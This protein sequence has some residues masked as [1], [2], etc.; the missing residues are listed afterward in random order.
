MVVIGV[1][2]YYVAVR[3][4]GLYYFR[5]FSEWFIAVC[6]FPNGFICFWVVSCGFLEGF[7]LFQGE[8]GGNEHRKW[9]QM[10]CSTFS[11]SFIN[12]QICLYE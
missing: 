1:V 6:L 10:V 12:S 7:G 8:R 2:I 9:K 3:L 11:T 5:I 4:G